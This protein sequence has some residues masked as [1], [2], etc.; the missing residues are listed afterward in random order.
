MKA[1]TDRIPTVFLIGDDP[2]KLG[3]VASLNR[4]VRNLTGVTFV[5]TD[6]GA[7]RLEVLYGRARPGAAVRERLR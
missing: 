5:T 7:K 3:L 1:A 6:L 2:V 4:P